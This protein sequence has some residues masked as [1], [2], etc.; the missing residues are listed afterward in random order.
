[1]FKVIKEAVKTSLDKDNTY[2]ADFF[3]CENLYTKEDIDIL[4]NELVIKTELGKFKGE[5]GPRARRY[6]VHGVIHITAKR[7]ESASSRNGEDEYFYHLNSKYFKQTLNS[8]A[9]MSFY[10]NLRRINTVYDGED[11]VIKEDL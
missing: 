6:H 4:E 1:M 9:G 10:V 8:L 11:Y 5:V 2:L 7:H 3:T